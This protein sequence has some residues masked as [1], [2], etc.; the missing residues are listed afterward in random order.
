MGDSH[1]INNK[2]PFKNLNI[3]DLLKVLLLS[4]CLLN[5]IS[6]ANCQSLDLSPK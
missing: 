4:L 5:F 2:I 1:E 3:I 6:V